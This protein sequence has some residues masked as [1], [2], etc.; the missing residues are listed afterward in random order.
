MRTAL[1]LF[2]LATTFGATS[3][4]TPY[5][6]MMEQFGVE[7]R[8]ILVDRVA[9]A[10][11]DQVDAQ[12]QFKTTLQKLQELNNFDGGNVQKMYEEF[13]DEYD[14]SVDAANDVSKRIEKIRSVAGDLFEEWEGEIEEYE[15]A[16]LRRRSE[17]QLRAT[18]NRYNGLIG[19]MEKAEASM[20]PVLAAFHDQVLSLKHTLNSLAINSLESDVLKIEGDVGQ[21]IANMEASIAEAESFIKEFDS[22]PDA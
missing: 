14:D 22:K 6:A 18:R 5:Y 11:E 2:S 8:D 9:D 17:G 20:A 15:S 19:S 16:D 1:L 12:E 10:R 7:K 13:S 4:S 21:L 3:C